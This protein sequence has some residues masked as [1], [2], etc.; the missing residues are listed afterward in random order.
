MQ[1]QLLW[2][3]LG[4][5]EC[6]N[7]CWWRADVWKSPWL[8]WGGASN[9]GSLNDV[10]IGFVGFLV[11][12]ILKNRTYFHFSC[13]RK[14]ICCTSPGSRRF[15]FRIVVC[16]PGHRESASSA[17]EASALGQTQ[18]RWMVLCWNNILNVSFS[19][20]FMSRKDSSLTYFF[21]W[22]GLLL[23]FGKPIRSVA[24]RQPFRLLQM[25][26]LLLRDLVLLALLQG[27]LLA[28]LWKTVSGLLSGDAAVARPAN[29]HWSLTFTRRGHVVVTQP[30]CSLVA[31]PGAKPWKSFLIHWCFEK[32]A[33]GGNCVRPW[34]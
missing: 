33:K 20:L 30:C 3:M 14:K 27:V 9:G 25:H 22:R 21:G 8:S 18:C 7:V 6:C 15:I 12:A 5:I 13:C 32:P 26:L 24:M 29:W 16:A 10:L 1:E 4:G 28:V 17:Q 34:S 2:C 23:S 31:A 11:F 19:F